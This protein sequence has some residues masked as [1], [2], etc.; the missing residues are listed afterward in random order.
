MIIKDM[1]N[2]TGV[3]FM[4]NLLLLGSFIIFIRIVAFAFVTSLKC[5]PKRN[6]DVRRVIAANN[7]NIRPLEVENLYNIVKV[8]FSHKMRERKLRRN[9]ILEIKRYLNKNVIVY[10][11]KKFKNDAHAI[12]TMLNARDITVQHLETI[13]EMM[14]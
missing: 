6:T 3:D 5:T 13:Q 10:P 1:Q 9:T 11:K 8:E 2:V 12:Y 7:Y 14:K 4:K